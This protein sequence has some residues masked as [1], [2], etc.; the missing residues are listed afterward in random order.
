MPPFKTK[1]GEILSLGQEGMYTLDN[2]KAFILS[3][4]KQSRSM[5]S[6]NS[7]HVQA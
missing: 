1:E 2:E 3:L 5:D 7:E 6:Q 4:E